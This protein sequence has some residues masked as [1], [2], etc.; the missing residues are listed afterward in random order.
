MP[1]KAYLVLSDPLIVAPR[2]FVSAALG[3]GRSTLD[4]W[5][6]STD[7]SYYLL[8]EAV[9]R[10]VAVQEM[11][12]ATMMSGGFKYA[13]NIAFILKNLHDWSDKTEQTVTLDV[14]KL[15]RSIE[16]TA[17]RVDWDEAPP[18]PSKASDDARVI[19]IEPAKE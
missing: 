7:D 9:A 12:L 18:A 15:V 16:S 5:L 2:S 19:D 8:K 11:Q 14:S 13:N 4:K 10:G 17:L 1:D 3:V 6:S